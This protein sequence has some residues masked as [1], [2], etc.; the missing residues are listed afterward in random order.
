MDERPAQRL[1]EV[2]AVFLKLGVI[3]F[4]GPA[5]HVGMLEDEVVRRRGWLTRER[6][7]DLLGASNII[8]GPTSTEMCIYLG[9]LRGGVIG[10]LVGG[11]SFILPAFLIVL[12]LA[13]A[14]ERSGATPEGV[15]LLYGVKP[16]IIA[17]VGV[18]LVRL[19]RTAVKGPTTALVGVVVPAL[20]FLGL[21]PVV[22]LLASGL[23]LMLFANARR[24]LT[25]SSGRLAGFAP[26][27]PLAVIGLAAAAPAAFSLSE[28]FL[29]FL[30]I[31]A[32][33]YGSGYVLLAY[34]R[35]DFVDRLGWLTDQQLLDAV[36]VGQFTPG[37]VFTTATFIGYLVG[38]WD[39]AV[40]ATVAIFLPSFLFV[41]T[42]HPIVGRLRSSTW[43][44]SFLDGVNA[45]AVGLMAAVAWQLADAAF[46]D[47]LTVVM[48]LVAVGLLA[49]FRVNS[50]W[51]VLG[52]GLVG[53][54]HHFL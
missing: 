38:G 44:S 40:V 46:V 15:A 16:V 3:G 30:K 22:L 54:A 17:I 32:S 19:G 37:P 25:S 13:W 5:A 31:G 47:A 24:L 23:A 7:L 45:A 4:G 42:V 9:Y 52:G 48:A 35:A 8:P 29:T 53:L 20:Y 28:L 49:T 2:L 34:L 12:G 41:A 27:V 6:F 10:M 39:G 18:A 36:A 50:V 26:G 1:T 43:A 14:Y 21:S 33:V 11:V 51:L